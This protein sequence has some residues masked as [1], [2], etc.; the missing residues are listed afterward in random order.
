M[1]LQIS[2][3]IVN[4]LGDSAGFAKFVKILTY[5]GSKW[6]IIGVV[7]ILL[8]FKKTR[9]MGIN[10]L[11]ACLITFV[12]NDFVIKNIVARSR[13]FIVDP[14]L[15]R[16]CELAGLELPDG[17]SMTSGHSAVSMALAISIMMYS[18]KLG[19]PAMIY[20]FLVG[21][22]RIFL[23]VHFFTDVLAGF[24]FGTIITI[25]TY[26]V[27]L[28][29]TKQIKKRKTKNENISPSVTESGQDS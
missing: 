22:S 15:T 26:F 9:K 13:P 7:A 1:D 28:F 8:I 5:G 2:R 24:A 21:F 3:W 4:H 19:I 14:S 18:W 20:S 11:F 27:I 23:C 17:Y 25:L 10:A 6:F 12:L 16:M 29:I